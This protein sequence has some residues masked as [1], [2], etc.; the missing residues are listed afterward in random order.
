MERC[1]FENGVWVLTAYG[2]II[3][4]LLVR[5][6][7]V[8]HAPNLIFPFAY[9]NGHMHHSYIILKKEKEKEKTPLIICFF[10]R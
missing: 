10:H 4:I 1:H 7:D 8:Y 2:L 9:I 5:Q 3:A 6:L